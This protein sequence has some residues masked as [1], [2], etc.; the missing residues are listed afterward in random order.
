MKPLIK[1][2]GVARGNSIW[3]RRGDGAL[4]PTEVLSIQRKP[5]SLNLQQGYE[6]VGH[7][8]DQPWKVTWR[9]RANAAFGDGVKADVVVWEGGLAFMVC[10][11]CAEEKWRHVYG[12]E[13][14]TGEGDLASHTAP[15]SSSNSCA[16][17]PR[18]VDV[19][20]PFARKAVAGSAPSSRSHS[21]NTTARQGGDA[22]PFAR[23]AEAES[24]W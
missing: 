24:L 7:M 4:E 14:A 17:T 15:S 12:V 18:A 5:K 20:I 3:R 8:V 6:R 21:C 13:S 10:D 11:P 1:V 16:T 9:R 2:V 23:K 22:R 19:A